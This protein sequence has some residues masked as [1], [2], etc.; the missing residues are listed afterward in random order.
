M[1][2]FEEE[3]ACWGSTEGAKHCERAC[4][5]GLQWLRENEPGLPPVCLPQ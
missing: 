4:R 3:G 5:R 1:R 2:R